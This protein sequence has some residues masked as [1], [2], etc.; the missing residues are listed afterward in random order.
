M[1]KLILSAASVAMAF[2]LA[3]AAPTASAAAG[4]RNAETMSAADANKD[5]MVSKEEFLAAMS[6]LYDD[7]MDAMKKM[8]AAEQAK[9]MKGDQ[10]TMKGYRAMLREY[11]GGR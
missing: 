5:G 4:D 3:T 8:P 7:K 1:N 11:G 10:M 2:G 9:M 6:K